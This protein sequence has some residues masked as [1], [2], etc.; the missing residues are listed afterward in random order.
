VPVSRRLLRDDPRHGPLPR[1]LLTLT[2]VTGLV[3]AVSILELGRVFVA[4]MTGNVVFTGFAL[5]GTPGFSLSASLS[6][7]AGF[8]TAA[9][10]YGA[11]TSR[12]RDDRAVLLLAAVGSELALVVA[13]LVF[14]AVGSLGGSGRS[15]VAG[16]LA[17][18]MGS[19]NAGAR[20]LAVPDLTTSVVTMTLTGLAVDLRT[21]RASALIRRFLAV[22]TMLAGAMVGAW[23]VLK[24]SPEATLALATALLAAVTIAAAVATRHP[25]EWRQRHP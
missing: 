7:L 21:G 20:R 25:A 3:D 14:T 12:V 17:L 5:V 9:V 22:V 4:N 8:L 24:V 19:Q 10:L 23:L 13:A 2:V 6:A 15:V 18:A 11:L 16:L 1:L